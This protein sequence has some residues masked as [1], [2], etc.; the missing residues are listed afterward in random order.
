MAKRILTVFYNS[1]IGI[2][3]LYKDVGSIPLGLAKY[4]KWDATFAYA[5]IN[6][7]LHDDNYEK[8]VYLDAVP[9]GRFILVSMCRYIWENSKRYEVLNFYH[10]TKKNIFLMMIA[11]FR[12]P[13]IKIYVKL[14]MGRL[15]L[16][17][18][19][20]KNKRFVFRAFSFLLRQIRMAPDV[21]TVETQKYVTTLDSMLLFSNKVRYLPNGFWRDKQIPR[22]LSD[23][24]ENIIL[25]VGRLGTPE[26]NTELLLDSFAE[27]PVAERKNWKLLLIGSY[28]R[29]IFENA[30]DMIEKDPSLR[31]NIVF[32]G[33]IE[34]KERL[35]QYYTRAAVFCLPSRW[36]GFPLVLPEAMHHGCFPIV[37]DCCDAFYDMLDSGKYG[38]IIPNEHIPALTSALRK[39]MKN[40]A[41]TVEHGIQG[42]R[43]ADQQFD[44]EQI[45]K[46]LQGYL[47]DADHKK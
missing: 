11:K 41:Y 19:I 39:A 36:E 15:P 22:N 10:M 42:K 4:Q 12:N 35:N 47:E 29:E 30:E 5:G 37:T 26:K 46:K 9:V 40:K 6:G 43:Y 17:E 18:K 2:Q 38:N 20:K 1:D 14:D 13:N 3:H 25:T 16:L 24:K 45:I 23:K 33:N 28:T 8:Y 44:W 32:T 31:E 21:Y 34:D 27:I 7:I